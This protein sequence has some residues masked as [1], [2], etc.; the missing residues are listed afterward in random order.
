[1][2]TAYVLQHVAAAAALRSHDGN[3]NGAR[4][5]RAAMLLGFVDARL[6]ALQAGREYTERQEHERMTDALRSA[7]GEEKLAELLALGAGWTEE[8]AA[9]VA[10][11]L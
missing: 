2:L 10:G 5:E 3:A 11:E 8:G 4:R 7:F 6:Q 1:V 9:A